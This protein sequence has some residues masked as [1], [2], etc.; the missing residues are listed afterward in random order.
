MMKFPVILALCVSL[1]VLTG[2][3]GSPNPERGAGVSVV[4]DIDH[5]TAWSLLQD[6]SLAHNYVPG[7]TRTEIMSD[8]TSG[9]GAHR[10]VYDMD[11]GY[12]EETIYRWEPGSGFTIRL[13]EG[14]KPMAPFKSVFFDYALVDAGKGKTRIELALRFVMPW[15]GLGDWIGRQFIVPTMEESLI[16]VAAGMKSFYETGKPATDADRARLAS[17]VSVTRDAGDA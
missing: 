10:R 6:F 7:L 3:S 2:C 12:I 1:L 4:A 15:G 11:G 16:E 8:A 14:E 17:Q 9:V 13:H 5:D